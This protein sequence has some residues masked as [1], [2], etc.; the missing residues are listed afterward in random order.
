MQWLSAVPTIFVAVVV[1]V[2][3]GLL[4]A[5]ATRV[6][7][8]ALVALAPVYSVSLIVVAAVVCPFLG[9]SWSLL[10]VLVLAVIASAFAYVLSRY[11]RGTWRPQRAYDARFGFAVLGTLLGAG[12]V[13]SRLLYAF[14]SP[15]NISQTYDNIF[16]LNAVQ[17][18]LH[19][20][21]ASSFT[22]GGMTGIPFYPA[23]WHAVVSLTAQ[24]SGASIP[25]AVNASNLVIGALVWPLGCIFMIQQVLG[26]SKTAALLA[27]VLSAAFGT[28]PIMMVDFG[29]LYPNLLS[30]SL[31]P[32]VLALGIQLLHLSAVPDNPSVMRSFALLLSLPGLAL[33][34]PSTLMAFVAFLTPAVIFSFVRS[35]RRWLRNWPQSRARALS[36]SATLA[37]GTVVVVLA[38]QAVRPIAEAAFWPPIHSPLGSLWELATNSEMNRPPAVVVSLLMALGIIAMARR[39]NFWWVLGLFGAACLLFLVVSSFPPGPLRDFVTAIWYN[40]SYRLAALMPTAAILM[41]TYG[42]VWVAARVR[43]LVERRTAHPAAGTG[44][45]AGS[46]RRAIRRSAASWPLLGALLMVVVVIT[47]QVGSVQYAAEKARGNYQVTDDSQLLTRDEMAVLRDM[48]S[49]VPPDAVVAANAWN[50]SALAYA[51]VDRRTIQLHVL[52]SSFTLNDK[53]VLD[54]LREAGT[55]PTVCPAVKALNVSYVLDFGKQEINGGS[56]PAPG[57]DNLEGSGVATLLSRHG[58]AKLFKFDGCR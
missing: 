44:A 7:G 46:G 42:A 33:A 22:V 18:I 34:H 19:T 56:H 31:L 17:Y 32:A 15:D 37:V 27:G 23:G 14:D 35:W 25:V 8:F 9:I 45:D 49:L 43:S 20:G 55:N 2:G 36:W 4:L 12:I 3:P 26:Q 41:A 24:L 52:S 39:R 1:L 53:I 6:R 13:G 57:L 10:P 11:T 58:D 30:I 16:H 48:D 28:F 21:Q 38:W 40:D 54:S 51:L 29:V 50:G 5:A 47:T